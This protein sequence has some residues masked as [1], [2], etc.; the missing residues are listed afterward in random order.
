MPKKSVE[1]RL[2]SLQEKRDALQDEI[3]KVQTEKAQDLRKR[4]QQREA[5]LG[6]V[7][8]QLIAD[9][10]VIPADTWTEEF[11]M[12]LVDNHL[13]RQRDRQLFG[14]K[15]LASSANIDTEQGA[16][17]SHGS[18]G[19]NSNASNKAIYDSSKGKAVSTQQA[20]AEPKRQL[21]EN[22]SQDDLMDEFNL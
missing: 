22:S 4:Q 21:I 9:G 7:I 20:P 11:L 17:E 12:Q 16:I 13:T 6:R 19:V 10:A 1:A 18:S 3:R 5:L 14:L 2:L 8:Y 15:P